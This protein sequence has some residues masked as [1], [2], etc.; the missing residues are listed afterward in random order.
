MNQAVVIDK[1]E[2]ALKTARFEVSERISSR[3]S[4]FD[5]AVR[6]NDKIAFIKT[7]ENI[8]NISVLDALELKTLSGHFGAAPLIVCE[9]IRHKAMPTRPRVWRRT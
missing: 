3:R 6:R 1:A 8:G 2:F 7:H 9:K 5:I 4:C